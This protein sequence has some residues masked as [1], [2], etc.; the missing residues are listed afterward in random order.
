MLRL[1]TQIHKWL[2]LIVGLQVL[3]W[4][5]GGLVMTAIPIERVRSEQ[6]IA[7]FAPDPLAHEGLVDIHAAAAAAG[8]TPVEATLRST[9]RG[10]V[11][12]LKA[13]D[14]TSRTLDARTARPMAP[15]A[16]K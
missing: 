4:V 16:E 7:E 14:G 9:L 5:L 15:L 6:H 10:P 3:G 12:V 2:A 11:W 8:L 1:S 13:A